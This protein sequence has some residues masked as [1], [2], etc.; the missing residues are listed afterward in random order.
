MIARVIAF[1][2]MAALVA[3][4]GSSSPTTPTP[5][6]MP[7][8]PFSM[9]DLVVGTG[10][11]AVAGKTVT[12]NYTGWLYSDTGMDHKGT[13][14]GTSVGGTPFSFLLGA[15]QVI[16]G[17]DQGLV[18][19]KAGGSRRLVIPPDLAYG[20]AGSGSIPPNATLVFD[21]DLLLVQ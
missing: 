3:C 17:F 21:V 9:T 7:T 2:S 20:A 5:T 16:T 14:F 10:A 15:G 1:F 8:A 11:E 6:P 18:G 19:M 4:G 12:I 13:Q